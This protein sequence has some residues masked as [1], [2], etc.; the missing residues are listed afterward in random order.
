TN[1]WELDLNRESAITNYAMTMAESEIRWQQDERG[2]GCADGLPAPAEEEKQGREVGEGRNSSGGVS[3]ASQGASSSLATVHVDGRLP[4][5][6]HAAPP[7]APWQQGYAAGAQLPMMASSLA[8][9]QEAQAHQASSRPRDLRKG[10]WSTEEEDYTARIIHFFSTGVLQLGE[11]T[12]LRVYLADKLE[13]DPMRITKKFTG[14]SCLGK[15]VYHS[16]E[17]TP[18]SMAEIRAAEKELQAL[19][20]RFRAR[21]E[22][23]RERR[24]EGLLV[25]GQQPPLQQ[26]ATQEIQFVSRGAAA[27]VVAAG[28]G[29]M[30]GGGGVSSSGPSGSSAGQLPLGIGMGVGPMPVVGLQH[31]A[32]PVPMIAAAGHAQQPHYGAVAAAAGG[33]CQYPS[34]VIVQPQPQH[35]VQHHMHQVQSTAAQHGHGLH[36]VNGGRL[37][38]PPQHHLSQQSQQPALHQLL[39]H[40]P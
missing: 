3:G 6:G 32:P 20:A 30:S 5:G 21:L 31:H 26:H 35:P 22:R 7:A 40:R 27:A 15:R 33:Y 19:E 24:V 16:C 38:T 11:G 14:N 37:P 18:A 39:L 34:G 10:K 25:Q 2:G 9:H 12:T 1:L 23:N 36:H 8:Q 4:T 28:G 29:G 17:R 13:C